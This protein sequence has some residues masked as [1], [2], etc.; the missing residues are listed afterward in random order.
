MDEKPFQNTNGV[1]IKRTG[2]EMK[3][4]LFV[5]ASVTHAKHHLGRQ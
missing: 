3:W 5:S 4:E 1:V 2:T